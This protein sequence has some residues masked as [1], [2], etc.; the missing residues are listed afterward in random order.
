MRGTLVLQHNGDI[1]VERW[2][3]NIMEKYVVWNYYNIMEKY[4]VWNYYLLL[5]KYL[6]L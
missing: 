2:S 3:Y 1:C 4:V 5:I 6:L